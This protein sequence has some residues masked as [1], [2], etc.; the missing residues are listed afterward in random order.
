MDEINSLTKIGSNFR[1]KSM[2]CLQDCYDEL[3]DNI[4]PNERR[5]IING[6]DTDK[7]IN[8]HESTLAQIVHHLT[9]FDIDENYIIP[10][11][12]GSYWKK[13][14]VFLYEGGESKATWERYIKNDYGK[15]VLEKC[16]YAQQFEKIK[17]IHENY[18]ENFNPFPDWG[19]SPLT[20][21]EISYL[22]DQCLDVPWYQHNDWGFRSDNFD[23]NKPDDCIITFGC[24]Y[25]YGTGLAEQ[26]RFSNL[27]AS[28]LNLKNYNFGMSGGSHDLAYNFGQYFIPLL[29]PKYVFLL[30]PHLGRS[31]HFNTNLFAYY[32]DQIKFKKTKKGELVVDLKDKLDRME[33]STIFNR[34]ICFNIQSGITNDE[35]RDPSFTDYVKQRRIH[36][37][38]NNFMCKADAIKNI[39]A[40]KHICTEN[41][42]KLFYLYADDPAIPFN[43]KGKT[44]KSMSDMESEIMFKIRKNHKASKQQLDEW[45]SSNKMSKD[46]ARDLQH[47]G[48][49]TNKWIADYFL[50]LIN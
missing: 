20:Q 45:Y 50:N 12:Y 22:K 23:I 26:E 19:V 39:H 48:T 3:V 42:S 30:G 15:Y 40:L 31:F 7:Q 25:V 35:I 44:G 34:D 14:R 21:Q 9:D 49:I 17:F 8:F 38:D 27:I 2:L 29:K 11:V 13:N 33:S 5:D 24:S 18:K 1:S 46:F 4:S 32:F 10:F 6:L 47:P 37:D 36:Y 41:N 43:K 28:E 16:G